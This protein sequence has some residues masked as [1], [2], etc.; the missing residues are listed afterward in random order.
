MEINFKRL[1]ENLTKNWLAIEY[2]EEKFTYREIWEC[3]NYYFELIKEITDKNIAIYI[4]N[5]PEYVIAYFLLLFSGKTIVPIY[6]GIQDVE[7][8]EL[9]K[10]TDVKI[11]LTSKKVLKI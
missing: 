3:I 6:T 8:K 1:K 10:Y 4:G 2:G 11:L 7:L 5:E 9:L